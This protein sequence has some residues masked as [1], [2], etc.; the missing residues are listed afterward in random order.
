MKQHSMNLK[1]YTTFYKIYVLAESV[2]K[3]KITFQHPNIYPQ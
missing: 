1:I 3:Q 2:F